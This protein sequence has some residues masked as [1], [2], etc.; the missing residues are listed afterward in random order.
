MKSFVSGLA[1]YMGSSFA[2]LLILFIIGL[3]NKDVLDLFTNINAIPS[4]DIL[5][6][7]LV[8]AAILYSVYII[9]CTIIGNKLFN[10]GVNVD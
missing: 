7:M 1:I 3:F 4:I 8:I 5:N 10:K 6:Y 9:L 2:S